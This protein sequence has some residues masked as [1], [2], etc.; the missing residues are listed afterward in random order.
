MAKA[1]FHRHQRV[2]VEP[3]GTWAVIDRVNPVWVKGFSEPVRVTYDCGLG[4]DFAAEELIVESES[5]AR[6][7][8]TFDV[9]AAHWRLMRARNKW[10]TPEESAHHP[11]PGTYPVIVTDENDWGGWRV[12]GAEYERDP[13]LIEMQARLIA[14]AP[15]LLK[16]ARDMVGYGR[17]NAD[18]DDELIALLKRA[19]QLCRA[20]DNDGVAAASPKAKVCV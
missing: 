3:V 12:P 5:E 19:D 15:K 16:L 13:H 2:Y 18:L 14:T 20:V 17:N 6:D 9:Q 4:R 1:A 7:S 8:D 11:F 10:Q